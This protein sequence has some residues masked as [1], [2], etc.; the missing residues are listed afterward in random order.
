MTDTF[1]VRELDPNHPGLN[2]NLPNLFRPT[3]VRTSTAE[4]LMLPKTGVVLHLREVS[5]PTSGYTPKTEGIADASRPSATQSDIDHD[6]PCTPPHGIAKRP[7]RYRPA[8]TYKSFAFPQTMV[9][10]KRPDSRQPSPIL[11]P[12]NLHTHRMVSQSVPSGTDLHTCARRKP[13]HRPS[14]AG[15]SQRASPHSDP[16]RWYHRS[17]PTVADLVLDLPRTAS[18]TAPHLAMADLHSQQ[19]VVERTDIVRKRACPSSSEVLAG[20]VRRRAY[21]SSSGELL[22]IVRRKGE[23]PILPPPKN[24]ETLL[25]YTPKM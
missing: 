6:R 13:S 17:V 20:F 23:V 2:P 22:D 12:N 15:A 16:D 8:P 21:P 1:H 10:P 7:E 19:V 14:V 5:N 11:P 3:V 4:H 9:S 25:K 18:H 24:T